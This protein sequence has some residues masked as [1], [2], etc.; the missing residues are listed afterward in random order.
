MIGEGKWNADN[1]RTR[2]T[3][4]QIFNELLRHRATDKQKD[5]DVGSGPILLFAFDKNWME[6]DLAFPSTKGGKL[7]SD[8]AVGFSNLG[9]GTETFWTLQ[10]LKVAIS[11][12][13]GSKNLPIVH[14]FIAVGETKAVCSTRCPY[15]T[16][17]ETK[18]QPRF[19]IVARM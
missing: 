5:K 16:V 9:R 15:L 18:P 6:I 14:R 12:S 10:I 1:L 3:R 4:G 7:E 17:W 8:K 19:N 2:E 13:A 11:G